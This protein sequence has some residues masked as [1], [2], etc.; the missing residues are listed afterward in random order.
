MLRMG[1]IIM[2]IECPV[3]WYESLQK[4]LTHHNRIIICIIL[5]IPGN[6]IAIPHNITFLIKNIVIQ[7]TSIFHKNISF[8]PPKNQLY[9]NHSIIESQSIFQS[10]FIL[11]KIVYDTL[12]IL[13][14]VCNYS[15]LIISFY[16]DLGA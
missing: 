9:K 3:F 15:C 8:Q 7:F 6:V 14:V 10:K 4:N 5:S 13:L 16:C 1:Y 2:F 12:C 11:I